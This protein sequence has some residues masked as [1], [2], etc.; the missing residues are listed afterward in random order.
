MKT[1]LLT[2]VLMTLV[3]LTATTKVVFSQ[4]S[5]Q[6]SSA[7]RFIAYSLYNFSKLIDWPNSSSVSTFQVCIVGDKRV[8]VELL[9]LAK[10]KKVGNATYNII[11][12]KD[13]SEIQGYSQI[14]YLSNANSG[15]ISELKPSQI[16]GV[17]LVT[18]RS[19][20]THQGSVIS[21][22]TNE[23]GT[24]GFEIAR[25]NAEKNQLTIQQQLER[26]AMNVI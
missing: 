8:Y 26:M 4:Q 16:K 7:E 9:N 24:M 11:Y 20:M 15:K 18:E 2:C 12:C 21:F 1:R 5:L 23:K 10:N 14:I 19:G 6:V 25:E 17:L 3:V 13:I 22:M